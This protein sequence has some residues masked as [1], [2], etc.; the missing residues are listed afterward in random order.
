MNTL[1]LKTET[2]SISETSCFK[3]K[4]G[5]LIMFRTGLAILM[6]QEKPGCTSASQCVKEKGVVK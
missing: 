4:K 1:Y 5:S 2:E 6:Y 3:H